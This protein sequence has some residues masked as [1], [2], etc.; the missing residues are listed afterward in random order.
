MF[1]KNLFN[2]V[3][4]AGTSSEL[5]QHVMSST[6]ESAKPVTKELLILYHIPISDLHI[7]NYAFRKFKLCWIIPLML[8]RILGQG[9]GH[10]FF[11]ESVFSSKISLWDPFF[12]GRVVV[13]L[14]N[15]Y[16]RESS[17]CGGLG[18]T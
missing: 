14:L 6:L 10:I 1:V 12:S 7:L 8:N 3:Y 9:I 11:N 2:E 4:Y 17:N 18:Y 13:Y 15:R 5:K 16:L